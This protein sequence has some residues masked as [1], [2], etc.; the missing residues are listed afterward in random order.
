LVFFVLIFI[1]DGIDWAVKDKFLYKEGLFMNTFH[2][3][4][5]V[6]V[7]MTAMFVSNATAFIDL[8]GIASSLNQIVQKKNV[9]KT[10]VIVA[11]L[12]GGLLLK[13]KLAK[14]DPCAVAI[15]T[16]LGLAVVDNT[17][18]GLIATGTSLAISGVRAFIPEIE[19]VNTVTDKLPKCL[20]SKEAKLA[21]QIVVATAVGHYLGGGKTV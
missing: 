7:V 8:D 3:M 4:S 15:A 5:R 16:G 11:G 1:E 2:T 10:V 14:E 13:E 21:A 20:T 18:A 12:S 17:K 9:G 19:A 6:F